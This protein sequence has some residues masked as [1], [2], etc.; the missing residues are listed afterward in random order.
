M[1]STTRRS[2]QS[3]C[4]A[5][6]LLTST[7]RGGN[8]LWALRPPQPGTGSASRTRQGDA[9]WTNRPPA[10][11]LDR[12]DSSPAKVW[13][14]AGR[15]SL[16]VVRGCPLGTDEDR[17]EWHA[18]GTAVEDDPGIWLRRW[19]YPDR[20]VRH[21]LGDHRLVGRARRAR[22][23]GVGRLELHV[24]HLLPTRSGAYRVVELQFRIAVGD[25]CWPLLSVVHPSAAD[26][27][28]TNRAAPSDVD[29]Q[30]LA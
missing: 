15:C 9:A 30:A 4:A 20:T 16:G 26:P 29:G 11:K 28:R 3:L 17:C 27:A 21:V 23:G 18:S 2:P 5:L 10:P 6:G 13:S 24:A 22:G 12:A 7:K 25:R 8:T 1:D 14:R 19:F